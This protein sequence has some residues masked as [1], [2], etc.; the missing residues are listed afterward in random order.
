MPGLLKLVTL[1]LSLAAL[2][3]IAAKFGLSLAF[4]QA[5]TSP[6]WP[7][8]GIAIAALLFFGLRVIPGIFL[9]AYIVNT[10]TGLPVV[11]SSAIALGNTLE[12][13]TAFYLLSYYVDRY[14]FSK[15]NH[16][17]KFVV[18][19]LLATLVSATV[20]V[21][22]LAVGGIIDWNIYGVLWS[23][24]WLGD[25]VGGLI[26]A[27]LL[28][29]WLKS[30]KID[31]SA[32][33]FIEAVVITGITLACV[34]L[35]FS[36][37]FIIGK[38][39]YP[40][41]FIYLPI[42]LWVAYRY[43]QKGA[44]LFLLTVSILAIYGTS[45]GYGPFVRESVNESLLL[46]QGFMGVLVIATLVLAA[47]VDESREANEKITESQHQ[48]KLL[49]EKQ[50]GFLKVAE[51]ESVLAENVFN[52]SVQ[53]IFI[54]D[55]EGIILRTNSAFSKITGYSNAQSIGRDPRFLRS[56][57]HDK[58]FYD[59][60]W[61]E[62]L[63]EGS[64]QGEVWDRRKNG[65]IFPT[66]QTMTAVR[67]EQNKLVQFISIFSDISEKKQTEERIHHL[68]HYDIVTGLKNRAAFHDQLAKQISYADRQKH[69]LA[70]LYLDLDNFKLINDASGHPVGD[71]LLK[72]IAT[73]I[74][75]MIREEDTIARLGGDEF[76]ILLVDITNSKDAAVVADKVLL[77]MAKPIL[78]EHTEVVVTGSVGISAYPMDGHNADVLL[79]NADVAMYRAKEK[80]RNNFQFYT[81]E[82]NDQ[83]EERLLLESDMR[84]ALVRNEF[85]LHFQP[86]VNLETGRI[87]GCEALVRW[88]HPE[89]GLIPPNVFIPVA[90]ESG[91]IRQLGE[92]VLY[93]AC[94]QQ[95]K[96][97]QRELYSIHMAV[98]ISGR[99]FISQQLIF[100]IQ[101]IIADT[102]IDP[103][104][105]ELELTESTIMENVEENI[106]VLQKLHDMGVQLSIDDFGTGYS[107]MAYLKRFP[108]D[109]LK[110][111]QSFVR[112]IVTDEDDA[113]IVNATT[114]LG[115][116]LHMQV[117]AEGVE[118]QEQL[119]FLKNNGCDEIQGYYFSRPVTADEFTELLRKE[120]NL[121]DISS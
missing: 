69:K 113:A 101:K 43:K 59:E 66:W 54:T 93:T 25:V 4:E 15:V 115:H 44:T 85:I 7:P 1:W 88:Q 21:T 64:W 53:A 80:G 78:L 106:T 46:L 103:N 12:A 5:N 30:E 79:K 19:I 121:H 110:I 87:I 91:L 105:L 95:K 108:I 8:T 99:Q 109:K 6:V 97:H 55:S 14:P 60:L 23:T 52:K 62:L 84:K 18:V 107:S 102:E 16:V 47:S 20:G 11:L 72:H 17:A 75:S 111:D 48:L 92:W 120:T 100:E 36:D 32:Y 24:W 2:Y 49:V 94:M 29:C 22:S 96:W 3:F 40:L 51:N 56:D 57:K 31:F 73:R 41:A 116:N 39:H 42:S 65:E 76:V 13:V 28:L 63:S 61:H 26:I 83:A 118:T 81:A 98:N 104:K 70:L 34:G 71:L 35:V 37:L 82:M 112:D 86:Q 90:E 33:Q 68:A 45:Q 10:M 119:Q 117:I 77:E 38:E 27:P 114:A 67:D 89:R 9:G 58:S 74:K 50:S